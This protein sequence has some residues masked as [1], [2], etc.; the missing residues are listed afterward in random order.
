MRIILSKDGVKREI[1]TPFAMCISRD[2]LEDLI[3]ALRELHAAMT[4]MNSSYGWLRV[5][6][7]HPCDAPP[8][9][10]PLPWTAQPPAQRTDVE[11]TR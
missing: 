7:S 8:N 5:D 10:P 11:N 3:R 2:D 4:E 9:T 6:P 1:E